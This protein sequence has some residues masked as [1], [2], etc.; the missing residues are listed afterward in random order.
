MDFLTTPE[1]LQMRREAFANDGIVPNATNAPDLVVWDTTS[2]VDLKKLLIG[3][4][5]RTADIQLSASGGSVNTQF[6]VAGGFHRQTTVFPKPLPDTKASFL[7]NLHHNTNDK[8]GTI[9]L[10]VNYGLNNNQMIRQDLTSYSYFLPPTIKLF[11]STGRLAFQQ[12][13]ISYQT[14]V[15]TNPLTLSNNKYRGEF[16]NLNSNLKLGL[17]LATNLYLR[18]SGGYNLV[19]ADEL[20]VNP[21]TSLDPNA[22]QLPFSY[23][24]NQTQKSWIFEPQVDYKTAIGKGKL[25][26]LAGV[27]WLENVA[28]G[29]SITATKYASD[30]FLY[31]LSGAGAITATNSYSQYRYN[32]V[33]ARVNYNLHD[34]YLLNLTGRRDGSSRFGPAKRVANFGAAGGGWIFSDEPFFATV[35]KWVSFGK[36]RTSYG[37]TGNDQIGDYRFV[38]TWEAS[39]STYQGISVLNPSALFNPDYSWEVN[40]K[41][42]IALE[43]GLLR[44]R[45]RLNGA[46]FKNICGNQLVSYALPIQTGFTSIGRNLDAVIR[47]SGLEFEISSLNIT[48]KKFSWNTTFNITFWRNRLLSF[49]GIETSSYSSTYVVGASINA[50][51]RYEFQ[52]IDP[53]TGIATIRDVDQNGSFTLADRIIIATPDPK[54]YGGFQNTLSFEKFQ[55]DMFFEFKKQ[56]GVNYVNLLSS[57]VPGYRFSNQPR[58]VLNRWQRPGDVTDIQRFTSSASS[59]AYTNATRYVVLSDAGFSDA[60]YLRLKTL[61]ISYSLTEKVCNKLKVDLLK[62][63]FQAQNILVLTGYVGADPENQAVTLLPPLRTATFGCQIFF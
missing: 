10:S 40:R 23:F 38:D 1:Y 19:L 18:A 34:R 24:A 35:K 48:R 9:D 16:Q 59:P 4:T 13:G 7:F 2:Y 30:L 45:V 6:L 51:R 31:S 29:T 61:A 57:T 49:P 39:S 3:G 47:N 21:S 17:K 22:N 58:I 62:V 27:T 5:A 20:S 41:A 26:F 36:L 42:E 15:G 60:S 8:K 11:D 44:D 46:W 25:T 37:V 43:F 56:S 63:F 28:R 55:F 12:K 33:F 32:A 52:G 54:F 50:R 53:S 14:T